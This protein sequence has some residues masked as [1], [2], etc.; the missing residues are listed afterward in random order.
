MPNNIASYIEQTILRPDTTSGQIVE[1]C[2]EALL[3]EFF[4]VCVPPIYVKDCYNKLS[5]SSVKI[6]TVVG[7]PF[8]YNQTPTKVE[9]ARKA[10]E[11]GANELDM[12]MNIAAFKDKN[13]KIV[14]SDI[15]SLVDYSHMHDKILKVII[16]TSFLTEEEIK[17]ACSIATKAGA[18][19]VK[20]STGFSSGGATVEAIKIMRASLPKKIKI[21]AS[22]GIKE[23]SFALQL[24]NAGADRIGTSAGIKLVTS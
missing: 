2:N 14:L 15:Q 21:K 3:Y 12:V 6:I 10:I 17:K 1:L 22:G 19:F 18:D 8:G 13:Y 7:F 16:E 23:Q 20:T 5:K 4:G 11:D 9:E 24:I